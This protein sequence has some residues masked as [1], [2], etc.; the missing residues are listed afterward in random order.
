MDRRTFKAPFTRKSTPDWSCPRCKKGLLRFVDGQFH[1]AERKESRDAHGGGAWEPDWI[2]YVY[3]GRL[4]CSNASC[5]ECV[6]SSGTGGVDV[7][8]LVGS[9]GELEQG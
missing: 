1:A 5:A 7:D 4:R 6:A 9:D 3:S 2:I 8:F